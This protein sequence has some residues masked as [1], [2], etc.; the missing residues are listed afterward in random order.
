MRFFIFI[1]F[2]FLI[3][4]SL[5]VSSENIEEKIFESKSSFYNL[6][7]ARLQIFEQAIEEIS[8]D[9]IGKIIGPNRLKNHKS[10]IKDRIIGNSKKYILY[11]KELQSE[12]LP[13][14]IKITVLL[15]IS[16][17]NLR[18]FLLDEGLFYKEQG[19][20]KVLPVIS[21]EDK[22]TLDQLRWWSINDL[23]FLKSSFLLNES[24]TFHKVLKNFLREHGFFG[25]TPQVRGFKNLIPKG[26]EVKSGKGGREKRHG[27]ALGKYFKGSIVL[28]GDVIYSKDFKTHKV[29]KISIDLKAFQFKKGQL[30]GEL[31]RNFVLSR[32][33]LETKGGLKNLTAVYEDFIKDLFRQVFDLWKRGAYNTRLLILSFKGNMSYQNWKRFKKHLSNKVREI[34]NIRDKSY[35]FKNV[36]YEVDSEMSSRRLARVLLKIYEKDSSYHL[37]VDR[38]ER[39]GIYFKMET[40][41]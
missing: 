20:L 10:I 3:F 8:F 24:K 26:F 35:A 6:E 32:E 22:V 1:F 27:L 33:N 41:F 28:I 40:H 7:K 38:I 21:F 39:N 29:E 16:N 14:G 2:L 25:L 19:F 34:K 9:A 30:L 5:R 18:K 23:N 36:T 12:K 15:K 4:F 31:K 11:M 17:E 37:K 13:D